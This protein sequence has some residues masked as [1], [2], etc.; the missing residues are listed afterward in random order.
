[1]D[2]RLRKARPKTNIANL[3]G[4]KNERLDYADSASVLSRGAV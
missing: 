4:G 1:M 2:E 3:N